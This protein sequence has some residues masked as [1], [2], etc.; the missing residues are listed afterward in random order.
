MINTGPYD[1]GNIA[2]LIS[3]VNALNPRVISLDI[4]FPTYTGSEEDE[5]LYHSLLA[6]EKVVIPS[7]IVFEGYDIRDNE[8]TSV[9]LTC[10]AE[11]FVPNATSGFVSAKADNETLQ[12]PKQFAAWHKGSYSEDIYYHFSIVTAMAFD[13]LKALNFIN[14]H[15]RLVDVDF[16]KRKREFR[17][18]S[19]METL[20]GKLSKRDIEGKIVMIGY[21]GPGTYDRFPAS[22]NSNPN[23]P[24]MYGL[25][26][27]ANIVA[28]VLEF[29]Q[30]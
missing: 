12:I 4:A 10:A 20:K 18:F 29:E 21:L 27:L 23:G 19:A 15:K 17:N 28:Q 14:N 8:I 9:Y 2:K 1:K 25:E 26:Y 30:K 24:Y 22:S 3:K 6:V 11:F 16:K 7:Q 13:S 5:D